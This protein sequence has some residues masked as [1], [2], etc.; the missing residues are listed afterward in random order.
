MEL[1]RSGG[2][3]ALEPETFERILGDLKAHQPGTGSLSLGGDGESGGMMVL[4]PETF[5]R[6]LVDVKVRQRSA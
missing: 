4:E 1:E 3:T 2:I 6:M 5:E